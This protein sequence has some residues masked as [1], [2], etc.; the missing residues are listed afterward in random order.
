VSR[1][2]P[3]LGSSPGSA[4]CRP[5]R[6]AT[7]RRTP[8]LVHENIHPEVGETGRKGADRPRS[9]RSDL[10]E[11]RP[12]RRRFRGEWFI[13]GRA[14][15]LGVPA[16]QPDLAPCCASAPR[17]PDP[18]PSWLPGHH[19]HLAAHVDVEV[20]GP[21]LVCDGP[22]TRC[23]RTRV[24]SSGRAQLQQPPE[25]W[26]STE[27]SIPDSIHHTGPGEERGPWEGSRAGQDGRSP[28][29]DPPRLCSFNVSPATGSVGG[30]VDHQLPSLGFQFSATRRGPQ[31]SNRRTL[32]APGE[33]TRVRKG[34]EGH[35]EVVREQQAQR[36]TVRHEHN[37]TRG[38]AAQ[39]VRKTDH[40]LL[41]VGDRLDG[42]G[43]VGRIRERARQIGVVA[44]FA[45][46]FPA[47]DP[48]R[49]RQGVLGA[50]LQAVAARD[51]LGR[52]AVRRW[53]LEITRRAAGRTEPRPEPPPGRG[54]ARSVRR[55]S[56]PEPA[57]FRSSRST[58]DE[59]APIRGRRDAS[60]IMVTPR[61][62]EEKLLPQESSIRPQAATSPPG[63]APDRPQSTN[64]EHALRWA[65]TIARRCVMR[66]GRSIRIG[67]STMAARIS[68]SDDAAPRPASL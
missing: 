28:F 7:V 4:R 60:A 35:R 53:G 52:L 50:D 55:R 1:K 59:P 67:W 15:A 42:F 62:P 68:A 23:D 27:G 41:H 66:I 51:G 36:I 25:N 47:S 45:N 54:R 30:R 56:G 3:I 5:G 2:G 17:W 14:P 8:A 37:D 46:V 61:A 49:P 18:T 20:A 39:P 22:G 32:A 12:D 26:V 65:A 58:R 63:A 31:P 34:A 48:P 43:S 10:L 11:V 6:C 9:A 21:K 38:L 29:R 57:R 33:T 44:D 24:R 19:A 16:Q 13:D 40:T 64:V